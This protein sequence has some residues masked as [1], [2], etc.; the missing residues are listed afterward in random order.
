MSSFISLVSLL[1][2]TT[3]KDKGELAIIFSIVSVE[4]LRP[5]RGSRPPPPPRV[6]LFGGGVGRLK[7]PIFA[8]D[9]SEWFLP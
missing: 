7:L 3:D 6:Y 2:T 8:L 4:C 1:V 9:S 5:S